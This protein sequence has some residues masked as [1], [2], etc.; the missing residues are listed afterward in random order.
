ML[1]KVMKKGMKSYISHAL[2][3]TSNRNFYH[4]QPIITDE[5]QIREVSNLFKLDNLGT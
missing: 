3:E 5:F 1:R 4:L 2:I